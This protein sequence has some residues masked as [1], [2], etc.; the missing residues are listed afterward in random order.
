M[1]ILTIHV[2]ASTCL[3][4][5][6]SCPIPL[7]NFPGHYSLTPSF[8]QCLEHTR[9]FQTARLA[10]AT[11]NVLSPLSSVTFPFMLQNSIEA[12][13]SLKKNLPLLY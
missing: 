9:C 1:V 5:F 3:S 7:Q 10:P 2:M 12:P 13:H 11:W 4:K 8:L 6:I